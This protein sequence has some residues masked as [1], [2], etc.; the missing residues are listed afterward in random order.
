MENEDKFWLSIW[1]ILGATFCVIVLSICYYS[2]QELRVEENLVLNGNDP[3]RVRC[4][5]S[6]LHDQICGVLAG[7]K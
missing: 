5:L 7:E 1:G 6:S 2:V 4:M 3:L